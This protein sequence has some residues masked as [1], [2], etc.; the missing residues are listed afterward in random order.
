MRITH[1]T[2]G[3]RRR[4]A[5]GKRRIM[6]EP[7]PWLRSVHPKP[8]PAAATHRRPGANPGPAPEAWAL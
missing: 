1:V 6:P 5:E 3:R 8:S 4:V 2:P 7:F